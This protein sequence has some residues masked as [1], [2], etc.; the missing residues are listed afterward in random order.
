M[1]SR[2]E[3]LADGLRF[4]RAS[5]LVLLA[6]VVV[7]VASLVGMNFAVVIPAFAREVLR[8]DATGFGLLMA[9]TGIGSLLAALWI[10]TMPEMR[11]GFIAGGAVIMGLAEVAAAFTHAMPLA[12]AAMFAVG[13]GA[14]GMAAT[15]NTTIQMRTPD[16]L[17]G[18][19]MSVYT[20]VFVGSTPVGGLLAGAVASAMGVDV[21]L[22]V[23]GVA[24]AA[25]GVIGLAW[26]GRLRARERL[27][28]VGTIATTAAT[29]ATD[30]LAG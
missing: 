5:E 28:S 16:V 29:G 11:V 8:V 19:V 3:R 30:A 20:V 9:A 10:A 2:Y 4:V 18:R 24:C 7:G 13:F 15:A 1:A 25:V 23:G 6:M 14:I 22:A 26:L 17:R 12:L 27:A 21:A